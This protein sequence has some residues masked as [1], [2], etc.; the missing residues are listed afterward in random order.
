MGPIFF[1][2]QERCSRDAESLLGEEVPEPSAFQRLYLAA[3][4]ALAA[5]SLKGAPALQPAQATELVQATASGLDVFC[6]ALM[7]RSEEQGLLLAQ[8][9][10]GAGL[11]SCPAWAVFGPQQMAPV[12]KVLWGLNTKA[13]VK[14]DPDTV[15]LPARLG[16]LLPS[17]PG[18]VFLENCQEGLHGPVEVLSTETVKQGHIDWAVCGAIP[19]EDLWLQ[20]CAFRAGA[21]A[22]PR[23]D[24]L[25]EHACQPRLAEKGSCGAY[26]AAY[27]PRKSFTAWW[28]C[29][30]EASAFPIAGHWQAIQNKNCLPGQGAAVLEGQ[31]EPFSWSLA[32][33][34]CMQHCQDLPACQGIVV[35]EDQDPSACYLRT[36]IK[37]EACFYAPGHVLWVK[38]GVIRPP[39]PPPPPP[40][41]P[42]PPPP[43]PIATSPPTVA[44]T[45][46]STSTTEET[47]TTATFT[48]TITINEVIEDLPE[49]LPVVTPSDSGPFPG[50]GYG[51]DRHAGDESR[52]GERESGAGDRKSLAVSRGS[53]RESRAGNRES[54]AVDSESGKSDSKSSTRDRESGERDRES[55]ADDDWPAWRAA[56]T[57]RYVGQM[58]CFDASQEASGD[59]FLQHVDLED[60]Q[61]LC[62]KSRNCEA[63]MRVQ[64]RCWLRTKV[65]PA[66]CVE[67]DNTHVWRWALRREGE[68]GGEGESAAELAGG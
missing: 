7:G 54:G 35:V 25:W 57:W 38:P 23:Y 55:G 49:A 53:D 66:S 48:T 28:K 32:P 41:P 42:P 60:C 65:H 62:L 18:R 21:K 64:S 52:A 11:F 22:L 47:T 51:G 26:N 15:F 50:T 4:M 17:K 34:Q 44:T 3:G 16:P 67:S 8:Q 40:S 29:W 27:H 68:S 39:A 36:A 10:Q 24:L 1:L 19:Q 12:T 43:P 46:T 45:K 20:S 6:F 14:V 56:I 13:I 30:L 58:D 63:F 5:F 61:R 37:V 33:A 59:A 9:K 31:K 2:L